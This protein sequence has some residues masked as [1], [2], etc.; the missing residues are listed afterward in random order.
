MPMPAARWPKGSAALAIFV[1]ASVAALFALAPARRAAEAKG[2]LPLTA[3]LPDRVPKGV[4]LRVGDPVSRWVFR[5]NGWDKKLPFRIEWAEITGGPDVTEA[6]HAGALDVGFGAS[7]PPIHAVWM[8]IPVRIVGFREYADR[9]RRRAYVFGISPKAQIR[10][11]ADLR[12]KR[13]AFSPSQVQAQIV[14]QTL[15]YQGI[16]RKD[17][18]LVELPSST[19][20][21]VYSDAL[22]AGVIDAAPIRGDLVAERYI[23]KFGAR[24]ARLLD[25]PPFRDDGAGIYVPETVLADPGK[26]AA[27]RVFVRYWGLAQA[28]IRTHPDELAAGYYVKDQGLSPEDARIMAGYTSNISVPRNWEG[29]IAYEQAAVD[30]LGP[31]TKHPRLDAATLFDRRFETIAGDAA[32][33][34]QGKQP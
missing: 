24:G 7:V 31:E 25:H 14:L 9:S 16:A 15:K 19:G 6:F 13:I 12:G 32:A 5:H 20:G 22:A 1:A 10:T 28:W 21:D 34:A 2:G 17:V 8:G 4:V 30:T 18:T 27:L 3:P 26:V 33:T 29:A 11:L 23:R